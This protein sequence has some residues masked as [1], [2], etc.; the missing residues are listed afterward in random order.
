MGR[1]MERPRSALDP[2]QR[3][4][5]RRLGRPVQVPHSGHAIE[6]LVGQ[7]A[8]K[9]LAAAERPE[10]GAPFQPAS[11]SSRQV[12]GVACRT[13]APFDGQLQPPA[14]RRRPPSR[15]SPARCARR[16]A[17]ADRARA[18][19]C[20]T[21]GSSRPRARRR[22]SSPGYARHGPQE[23]DQGPVVNHDSF[24]PPGGARGVDHVSRIPGAGASARFASL[25][26]PRASASAPDR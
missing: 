17:A 4:P 23:V 14:P 21:R 13:V 20:R 15:E 18:P 9:R 24:G 19:R 8:G 16:P 7:V 26:S 11:I 3:R 12:A 6:Q 10:P 5:D 22:S 25:S 1:P 2:L